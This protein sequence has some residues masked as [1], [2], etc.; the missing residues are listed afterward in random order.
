M[1]DVPVHSVQDIHRHDPQEA[2]EAKPESDTVML[3][4]QD[5]EHLPGRQWTLY[6]LQ[7]W[8]NS[9]RTFSR[10]VDIYIVFPF[11]FW[12]IHVMGFTYHYQREFNNFEFSSSGCS[13]VQYVF[14]TICVICSDIDYQS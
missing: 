1:Q 12:A 4:R 7:T 6:R 13:T 5:Q 2:W 11:C 8:T 3:R 10:S 9:C 14:M